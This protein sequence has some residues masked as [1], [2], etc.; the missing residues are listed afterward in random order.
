[1]KRHV[2]FIFFILVLLSG[3]Q[4]LHAQVI[5]LKGT[6]SLSTDNVHLAGVSVLEKGTSNSTLT[7]VNGEFLISVSP[8]SV[9]VFSLQ[10]FVTQELNISNEA[11]TVN[12]LLVKDFDLL[13]ELQVGYTTYAP[14]KITGA[15]AALSNSEFNQ[16][17]IYSVADLFQG[18]MAGLSIYNRGGDPNQ[19]ANIRIRGISTLESGSMPL[20][21]IDGVLGATLDNVDPNDI[22]SV[23]IL[24]DASATSI[25]GMRGAAGVIL[26]TTKSA[27]SKTGSIAIAY[28]G[29]LS[30]SEV[31]KTQP[32]LSASEY[33]A[34]GG[35]DIGS[36]TNW[37]QEVTRVGL[38]SFHGISI[39]GGNEQ[40]TF[41][42]STNF[43]N[44]NG[45]LRS[46]DFDQV[47]TRARLTHV[48]LSNR[49][50]LDMN[51]SMTNRN[52]NFSFIEALRYAVLY[53]PTA[54]IKFNSGDYFQAI[55]FDNYNPVAILEQN[56]N[57]GIRRSLNYNARISYNLLKNLEVSVH[58]ASQ[59]ENVLSG[60]YYSRNSLF[61]GYYRGG[62]ARRYTAD[63][64]FTLMETYLNYQKHF[65]SVDLAATA[66][67]SFQQDEEQDVYLSMGN[68]PNDQ[69]GYNALEN[70]G[71]LLSGNPNLLSIRSNRT[72]VNKLV[73]LFSRISL[74]FNNSMVV[75]LT[76]RREGSNKLGVNN[77]YGL[78]Y[79]VGLGMDLNR[80][81]KISNID[82]LKF[83]LGYGTSG[84]LPSQSGL[85]KDLYNYS[86]PN[87]GTIQWTRN[88]NPDLKW[89]E[90]T[91]INLG[92]DANFRNGVS[93]TVDYYSRNVT[94]LILQVNNPVVFP[95]GTRYENA[96]S[97][98]TSGVEVNVRYKPINFG[99]LT[100]TTGLVAAFSKT[101][102]ESYVV[103]K[104]MRSFS[105]PPC[106]C[107]TQFI[108]TEVG[109]EIGEIWGPVFDG[110]NPNGTPRFKDVN[111]DG[112][113]KSL[114]SYAL[115]ADGDFQVL[116]SGLPSTELG[117][118]NQ[119]IFRNWSLNAFFRGAFGHSLMNDFRLAYEPENAGSLNSYNRIKS[120]KAVT[121]LSTNG[122]SS[123]YVE[124][125]DFLKLDNI[126]FSYLI[127]R[128]ATSQIRNLKFSFTVQNAFVITNYSGVDP[129]PVLEDRGSTDNGGFRQN[130]ADV[131]APGIDR[132][133]NYFPARTF[134]V[135]ILI[136]L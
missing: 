132:R 127:K 13:D 121:G 87:G 80:Y 22:E 33:V 68:F 88:G 66:G 59:F 25:Y 102:L 72:P 124:K 8:N 85:S 40:T 73:A 113:D 111:G 118:T 17:N 108:K 125:A 6:V 54:P 24:K 100:W 2:V 81:L 10:G 4:L 50:R 61:R 48:A 112:I 95:S 107:S 91:E 135:G 35:N 109:K 34:A 41:R 32:S 26:I 84:S 51:I 76:V 63:R 62:L 7:D 117:W 21:V 1:M 105:G 44:V 126:S 28:N 89:Q 29:S 99:R 104:E 43:R 56:V 122:Y 82:N 78:F 115:A 39:S 79:S 49:L 114:A 119:L 15:V 75:N 69:L 134:S 83:R 123:L 36:V 30:A 31:M 92:M 133:Q 42:V 58:Y 9:L 64:N 98:H 77:H 45:I 129:E 86:F 57:E 52:S 94:D 38:S 96:A 110:V 47:N 67:Y 103:N 20:I 60:E 128:N 3:S 90:N 55:L 106:G 14:S 93:M 116:G 65:A 27:N 53:N 131:L 18:K 71:D 11:S 136:G 74:S 130:T 12:I 5:S 70:A 97:L 16:G 120:T 101:T 19:Q 37:Q 23:S 46:S